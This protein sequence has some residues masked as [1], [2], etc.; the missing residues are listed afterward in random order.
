[1][2]RITHK[3]R[4]PALRRFSDPWFDRF[5]PFTRTSHPWFRIEP[6]EEIES[7]W[8]EYLNQ[9]EKAYPDLP[10]A[11]R[12][13]TMDITCDLA[14]K[15]D[16]F[17]LTADLP[18]MNKDEVSINVTDGEVEISAEHKESKEEKAKGYIRKERAHV[19]YQRTLSLPAEIVASKVAAKMN[20]GILTVEF[21]KK[22]PTKVE[23][24]VAVKVE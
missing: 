17:V 6:W 13:F 20:N 1:M 3:P 4:L 14:D 15:G 5:F 23:E 8:D 12:K 10:S 21:P 22:T 18:G 2:V 9:L 16:K 19:R 11:M 24:P 7:T